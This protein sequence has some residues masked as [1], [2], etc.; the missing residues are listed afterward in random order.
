MCGQWNKLEARFCARCGTRLS[1]VAG[2]VP[3]RATD[4]PHWFFVAVFIAFFAIMF[5]VL[6]RAVGHFTWLILPFVWVGVIWG[7]GRNALRS[8]HDGRAAM[9]TERQG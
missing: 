1:D 6:L 9:G 3:A 7:L 5:L 4:A 8:A 2:A